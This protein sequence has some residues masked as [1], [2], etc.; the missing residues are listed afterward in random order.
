MKGWMH[1]Q[2]SCMILLHLD[3]DNINIWWKIQV[4]ALID[5]NQNQGYLI[6]KTWMM[7][8]WN[9]RMTCLEW[10]PTS[11]WTL[12][13]CSQQVQRSDPSPCPAVFSSDLPSTSKTWMCWNESSGG[14]WTGQGLEHR[15]HKK[16]LSKPGLFGLEKR[17]QRGSLTAVYSYPIRWYQ[18]DKLFLEVHSNGKRSS[19]HRK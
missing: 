7:L 13:E 11:S 12:W 6:K 18:E 17:N 16:T 10:Q 8:F 5:E 9:D 4:V 2:K 19:G 15:A 3:W 14:H 1:H